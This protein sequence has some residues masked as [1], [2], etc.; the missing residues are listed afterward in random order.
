MMDDE[1]A[2]VNGEYYLCPA[3]NEMVEDFKIIHYPVAAMYGMGTP[4]D[5]QETLKE[6]PW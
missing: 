2:K 5:L 3:F 1:E 6:N 4:D